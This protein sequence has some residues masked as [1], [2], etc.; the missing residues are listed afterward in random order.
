MTEQPPVQSGGYPL[1]PPP[2]GSQS[3]SPGAVWPPPPGQPVD[4]LPTEAY[5]SWIRRVGAFIIDQIVYLTF[6]VILGLGGGLIVGAA[7][8]SSRLEGIVQLILTLVVLVFLIWN[9]GYRQG[10]TGSTIGKSVLKFKVVDERDGQP[11]GF[12]LSIVR[13]FAHFI[14]S[15]IFGIGYLLPLFTAK[16][17]TIADMIMSTVCLPNEPPLARRNRTPRPRIRISV[18]VVVL[19]IAAILTVL[20][21]LTST[22][23]WVC[24]GS[25][26][27]PDCGPR[28][29]VGPISYGAAG[30]FV[31]PYVL[32]A[33][34]PPLWTAGILILRRY[35][36]ATY[37]LVPIAGIV[38]IIIFAQ[39]RYDW[40]W[41]RNY[42]AFLACVFVTTAVCVLI[43]RGITR[44]VAARQAEAA[45]YRERKA[46]REQ[47]L[48]PT[49][50]PP[51]W[52]PD[53]GDARRQRHW[54]GRQ[55]TEQCR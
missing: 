17:Q 45:A 20:A 4:D 2:G 33:F 24:T 12:G 40:G 22:S 1:P 25:G 15:I 21:C 55:W 23:H 10:T 37:A 44:S 9:W 28:V 19:A 5:A 7:G 41:E 14:D 43:A 36:M 50:P 3:P 34:V 6:V 49:L 32:A 53:P 31:D 29:S 38:A 54:D 46:A 11:I 8:G 52:Y 47:R 26:P 42:F 16:R 18:G 30:N 35:Y 48:T 13:Y 51:G 39:G 27:Y